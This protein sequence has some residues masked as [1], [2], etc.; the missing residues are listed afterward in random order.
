MD[1]NNISE[2]ISRVQRDVYNDIQFIEQVLLTHFDRLS[3]EKVV[4]LKWFVA[5]LN[6][7]HEDFERDLRNIQKLID[8]EEHAGTEI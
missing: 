1:L 8:K 4:A 3:S 5:H 2:Y 7:H 6:A